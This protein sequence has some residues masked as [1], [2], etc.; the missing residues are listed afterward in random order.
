M[1]SIFA[2]QADVE[3]AARRDAVDG[4]MRAAHSWQA[5]AHVQRSLPK[6]QTVVLAVHDSAGT[7]PWEPPSIS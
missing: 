5:L 7:E 6:D 2:P 1:A 4:R 3:Q